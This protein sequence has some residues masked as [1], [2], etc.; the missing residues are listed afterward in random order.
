MG[1]VTA[2]KAE[3]APTPA[4]KVTAMKLGK[5]MKV[6]TGVALKAMKEKASLVTKGRVAMKG[7]T[8][9]TNQRAFAEA[10]AQIKGDSPEKKRER[11][12]LAKRIYGRL[13][14]YGA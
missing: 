2:M 13:R 7:E 10:A 3:K 11:L 9:S 5:A 14:K 1:K 6:P 4:P 12:L 8:M